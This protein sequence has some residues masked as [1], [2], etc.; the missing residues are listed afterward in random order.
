MYLPEEQSEIAK[1]IVAE[2][3]QTVGP[4]NVPLVARTTLLLTL[5]QLA[6]IFKHEKFNEEQEWRIISPVLMDFKPAFPV[7][8]EIR[9]DFRPGKSMLIPYWRVPLKDGKNNFPLP[10]HEVVVG[11][12][13]NPQQSLRSVRSLLNSQGFVAAKVRSSNIPYRNW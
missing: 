13:P 11:P 9:L 6:P 8:E 3:E 10:L 4:S 12:N 2:V 7:G 1:A 5:H